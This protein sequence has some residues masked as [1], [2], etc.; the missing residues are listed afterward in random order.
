MDVMC[1]VICGAA[2]NHTGGELQTEASTD[3]KHSEESCERWA[4]YSYAGVLLASSDGQGAAVLRDASD[5][6]QEVRDSSHM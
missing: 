6:V 5:S 4:I 1:L 3:E 2:N